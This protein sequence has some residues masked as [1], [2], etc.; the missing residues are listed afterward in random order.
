VSV[1]IT[2]CVSREEET[3]AIALGRFVGAAVVVMSRL[4]SRYSGEGAVTNL[5]TSAAR[6]EPQSFTIITH[7]RVAGCRN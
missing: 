6:D 1:S 4:S 7:Q 2:D 5:G 3:S